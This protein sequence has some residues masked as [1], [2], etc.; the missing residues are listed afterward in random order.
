[1]VV[2]TLLISRLVRAVDGL[3]LAAS[4]LILERCQ[5][6]NFWYPSNFGSA[7]W[8]KMQINIPTMNPIFRFMMIG[9]TGKSKK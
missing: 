5:G 3:Q 7:A 4:L 9:L 6:E 8:V 2:L 1:M